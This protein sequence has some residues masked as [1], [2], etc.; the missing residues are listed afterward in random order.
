MKI[1]VVGGIFLD[2]YIYGEKPHSVEIIED[3]GGAG[4]NVAFGFKKLGHDVLFFSNIGDDY[5]G[6]MI[7]E[8]L[9]KE[10]FDVSNIAI[11]QADTGIH[12]AYNERTI[13]VKRGTNDL[14]VKLNHQIL[15]SCDAIFVNTEVPLET[16]V[17]V[18]KVHRNKKIFLEAGPRRICEDAIKAFAEDVVTIGNLQECEKIRCDVV[19]MGY[20]GAKWDELFVEG[21]GQEYKYTI[22]CGDLFD[23]ILIDCLLKGGSREDCLKKA[24]LVAQE[25][26]KSI[27][28][29]FNK[30]RL[31]AAFA[32]KML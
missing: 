8:R 25:M 3:C 2:I 21:D 11:C 31:L 15:S 26:A 18:L 7:I 19:K 32:E 24:V 22:G 20:K 17:E 6:R 27:K 29:A 14:P 23:V 13:A 16:V 28:G 5:K 10:N 30:M 4:L 9:K 1:G 12:I